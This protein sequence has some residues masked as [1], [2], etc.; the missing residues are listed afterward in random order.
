MGD[1]GDARDRG[2]GAWP[3]A[4][5]ISRHSHRTVKIEQAAGRD[6]SGPRTS[7]TITPAH[8]RMGAWLWQPLTLPQLPCLTLRAW[9]LQPLA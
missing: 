6:H 1:G 9:L 8:L 3:T 2:D 7:A 5:C 4:D